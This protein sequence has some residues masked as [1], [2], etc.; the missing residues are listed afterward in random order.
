MRN[1]VVLFDWDGTLADN[2][3]VIKDGI[4]HVFA[5]FNMPLWSDKDAK[6][7]IRLTA[8]DL[9][10]SMFDNPDD[11]ATAL[12]IYLSYVEENHLD[13]IKPI[14]G[15]E[16]F[17]RGLCSDGYVLG[18]VSNKTQRFLDREVAKLGWQDMFNVVIGAGTAAHDKPHPDSI[19]L[20]LERLC[21]DAEDTIYVGDTETD[22]LAAK[23]AMV[24]PVFV[25]YGLGVVGDLK[26]T[27]FTG[28]MPV[29]CNNY[30]ELRNAISFQKM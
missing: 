23:N 28:D 9:Y 20:A 18:I 10:S 16:E 4:N 7:N 25:T 19:N 1:K 13:V 17:V 12:E 29:I 14:V 11:V 15:A 30:N 2:F 5:H 22:M 3:D 21:A 8:R 6:N 27:V 26:K 24:A